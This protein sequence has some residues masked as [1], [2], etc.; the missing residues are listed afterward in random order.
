MEALM[1]INWRIDAPCQKAL[2]GFFRYCTI[3]HLVWQLLAD[4]GLS[5]YN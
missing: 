5:L 3:T 1:E 4:S 2:G